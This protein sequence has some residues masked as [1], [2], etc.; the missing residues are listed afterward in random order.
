MAVVP[1]PGGRR[2]RRGPRLALRHGRQRPGLPRRRRRARALPRRRPAARGRSAARSLGGLGDRR[3]HRGAGCSTV[4]PWPTARRAGSS[5][6]RAF[7]GL[8]RGRAVP[9]GERGHRE[10]R[11]GLG[12]GGDAA[13]GGEGVAGEQRAVAGVEVGDLAGRVAGRGDDLERADAVAGLERAGRLGLG[14]RVAAAEL[15]VGRLAGL[16]RLVL[17]QQL[18]VAGGDQDLDARAAARPGRRARRCGPRG[19]G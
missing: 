11:V 17:R 9:G 16:G 12:G 4:R 7:G 1:R 15:R 18:R 2:A 13:E 3:V 10:A 14:A 5:A 8:E 6:R 19:R